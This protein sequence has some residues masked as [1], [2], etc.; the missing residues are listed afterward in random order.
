ME[1]VF[2]ETNQS[3]LNFNAVCKQ[4]KKKNTSIKCAIGTLEIPNLLYPFKQN[5]A[6]EEISPKRQLI[7]LWDKVQITPCPS[8]VVG[9]V[10]FLIL[11]PPP[12]EKSLYSSGY[13]EY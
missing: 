2:L 12:I 1:C 6:K 10:L 5:A 8:A 9:K 4:N 7:S 3:A 11:L 13:F